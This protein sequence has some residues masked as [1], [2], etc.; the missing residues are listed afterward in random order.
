MWSSQF[1]YGYIKRT[2][3]NIAFRIAVVRSKGKY[4]REEDFI[5]HIYVQY[6]QYHDVLTKNGKCYWLKVYDVPEGSWLQKDAQS[7]ML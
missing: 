3:P 1:P 5:E 2:S 6:A 4:Y 7:R